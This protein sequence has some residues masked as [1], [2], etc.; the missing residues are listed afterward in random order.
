[1]R[2]HAALCPCHSGSG[3]LARVRYHDPDRFCGEC[4]RSPSLRWHL[5]RWHRLTDPK[6]AEGCSSVSRRLGLPG[7]LSFRCPTVMAPD[8]PSWLAVGTKAPWSCKDR[9]ILRG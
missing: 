6:Y 9:S 8:A 7:R 2:G 3:G 5:L 4:D 1:M